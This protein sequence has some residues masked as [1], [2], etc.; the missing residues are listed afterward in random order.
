MKIIACGIKIYYSMMI[1][2][3]SLLMVLLSMKYYYLQKSH[4]LF[5][6][7]V[8]L[9]FTVIFFVIIGSVIRI[10]IATIATAVPMH[11]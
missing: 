2:V 8:P 9:S 11:E 1:R 5:Y 3:Y 4:S 7:S 6:S 10:A